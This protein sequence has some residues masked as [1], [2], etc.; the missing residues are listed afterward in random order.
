MKTFLLLLFLT[1]SVTLLHAAGEDSRAPNIVYILADDLGYGDLGCYGQTRYATP[2]LDRLAAEGMRFTQH[3]A[4]SCVCA[5]SRS[6]LMTGRH[7]GHTPIRGNKGHKPEGQ[8]PL[9][10]TS[11]TV[12]EMLQQAGYV[13]GAFGKWGLG[14][15]GSEGD[16]M[17]QGFDVF[18]GYNCQGL[19]H[20]YF[21]AYLWHNDRKVMLKKNRDDRFEQYSPDLIQK[22]VLRFIKKN[23]KKKFFLYYPMTLPHAEL[24]AILEAEGIPFRPLGE[25]CQLTEIACQEEHAKVIAERVAARAAFTRACCLELFSCPADEG[26]ILRAAGEVPFPRFLGPGEIFRVR[27]KR[28]RNYSRELSTLKLERELG[29]VVYRSTPGL[30]VNLRR[31]Q[32]ELLG[33]LTEGLFFLGLKLSEVPKGS[34][35]ARRPSRRPFFH[36]AAMMPKLA[37]CMVNLARARPG[38]LVL[39]PFCGT[40]SILI[41]AALMGCRVVGADISPRMAFGCLLNARYVGVEPE[42][43]IVA[44]ALSPP[45]IRADRVVT[46][47]PYGRSATTAGRGARELYEVFLSLLPELLP[48]GHMACLAAPSTLEVG[49]IASQAGL[50][51]VETHY[52]FVHAN[53]TRELVVL[54]VL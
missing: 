44:D 26:E 16:P 41:E 36:P 21:P 17:H 7:T 4:G 28:V 2:H 14:Y 12:A 19:A 39:D 50:K 48:K 53:L 38:E 23:R 47:P 43:I 18:Y 52:Y 34:F 27:V 11:Y 51:L 37:R 10:D 30:K 3:Y 35:T 40:G 33:V 6:V 49:Q 5:P 31:P 8:W 46:D 25:L 20:N 15:P 1:A 9:P 24:R 32:V 29:A 45:C 22:E 42:A 13:T 54:A